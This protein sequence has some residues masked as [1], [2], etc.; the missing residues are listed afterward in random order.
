MNKVVPNSTRFISQ[1][2]F[3]SFVLILLLTPD[4]SRA[5]ALYVP[6]SSFESQPT[7]LADPRVD[8]WQ[9]A[10]QPGTFDPNTFGAWENLAGVFVNPDPTNS[11]HIQNADGN[12]LAYLFGYPQVA[13]FQDFNS[14]DWSN[15]AP[16][17]A[18]N[19]R[20]E[21]GKSYS[22][23]LGLTS[24]SVQPLNQGSTIELTLYYRDAL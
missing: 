13:L 7:A 21:T 1:L 4:K 11:A 2:M 17:H 12:Q 18:F 16:T 9:K 15:A 10:P 5:G 20:F 23:T 6:N 24:S 22:L 3:G 8:S 14:I 19:S